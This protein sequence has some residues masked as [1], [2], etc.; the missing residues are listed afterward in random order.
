MGSK[1]GHLELQCVLCI[2]IMWFGT[3]VCKLEDILLILK[4][5]TTDLLLIQQN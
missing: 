1:H 3:G 5:V 4:V 2:Y